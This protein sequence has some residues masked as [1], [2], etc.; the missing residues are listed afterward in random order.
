MGEERADWSTPFFVVGFSRSGTTLLATL[1]DNHSDICMSPETRFCFGV[2]PYARADNDSHGREF[3]TDRVFAYWRTADLGVDRPEFVRLFAQRDST[4]GSA[5]AALLECF[6]RKSGKLRVGEKSPVHLLYIDVLLEW[7]PDTRIICIVRDG[8]DAVDSMMNAPFSHNNRLRHAGEWA[9][10][11]RTIR[12]ACRKYPESVFAIRYEDLVEDPSN[13]LAMLCERLNLRAEE[14]QLQPNEESAVVPEWEYAWKRQ[15]L[16][17]VDRSK[18]ALWRKR[19]DHAFRQRTAMKIVKREL[20]EWD[21]DI[22]R[23]KDRSGF[24]DLPAWW[25]S[26]FFRGWLYRL[27]RRISQNLRVILLRLRLRSHF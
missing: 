5:F 1:L 21:Y 2:P 17:G 26:L 24:L 27:L 13:T 23:S 20:M 22:P 4:Y 11:S 19:D 25:V 10:Q 12:N 16:A 18:V 3:I 9:A 8:R 15:S 14:G 6:R 7:F